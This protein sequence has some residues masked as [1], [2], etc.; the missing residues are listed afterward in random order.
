MSKIYLGKE[1]AAASH[2]Q[3]TTCSTLVGNTPI[4]TNIANWMWL[5]ASFMDHQVPSVCFHIHLSLSHT[6]Y[7]C[8]KLHEAAP[9][10]GPSLSSMSNQWQTQSPNGLGLC[11]FQFW[12]LKPFFLLFPQKRTVKSAFGRI[13]YFEQH[14]IF[15]SFSLL[16]LVYL[17]S[18]I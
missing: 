8:H 6:S 3:C 5:P 16:F 2:W 1:Y 12:G 10:S 18:G 13:K 15:A 9:H 17:L 11:Y 7:N 14:Q 4:L